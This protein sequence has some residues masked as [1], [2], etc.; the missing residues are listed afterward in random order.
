M[1]S[2][3]K[4]TPQMAWSM[5]G[6]SLLETGSGGEGRGEHKASLRLPCSAAVMGP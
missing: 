2:E 6:G 3:D 4:G 5:I 1:R